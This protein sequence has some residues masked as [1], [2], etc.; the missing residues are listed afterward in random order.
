MNRILSATLVCS[1]NRIRHYCVILAIFAGVLAPVYAQVV[2]P[3]KILGKW[4]VTH[5]LRLRATEPPRFID[6]NNAEESGG[7]ALLL[8]LHFDFS[9]GGVNT[10]EAWR[11]NSWRGADLVTRYAK[12]AVP[13]KAM[14]EGER[15][16]NR[17]RLLRSFGLK[18]TSSD[19]ALKAALGPLAG[20]PITLY[21]YDF[22]RQFL[23]NFPGSWFAAVGDVLLVPDTA[24]KA[25]DTILV[26]RRVPTVRVPEHEAFCKEA[27]SALDKV[28]CAK[29][30]LWLKRRYIE[31]TTVCAKNKPIKSNADLDTKI[32]TAK[33]AL[34]ACQP[35]DETCIWE[36]LDTYGRML[37]S[38]TPIDKQC[39]DGE[40]KNLP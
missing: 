3:S 11:V 32:R 16:A 12:Q 24:S 36:A 27:V 9:M 17:P 38:Y 19:Y 20:K 26:L 25:R 1:V 14:F 23:E 7:Y 13:M 39:I 28:I 30:E 4:E 35:N 37:G 6:G 5:I 21:D 40:Y 10:G 8:G 15:I 34:D 29:R 22:Q 2:P 31:R 33:E 18:K